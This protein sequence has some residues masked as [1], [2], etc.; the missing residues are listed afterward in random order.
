MGGEGQPQREEESETVP[1]SAAR[2]SYVP[3]ARPP[4]LPRSHSSSAGAGTGTYLPSRPPPAPPLRPRTPPAQHHSQ[5][6]FSSPTRSIPPSPS[7]HYPEPTSPPR[8]P[9]P[10]PL[11]TSLRDLTDALP[12]HS[13]QHSQPSDLPQ[14]TTHATPT[15]HQRQQSYSHSLLS[16][17]ATQAAALASLHESPLSPPR[18]RSSGYGPR[19]WAQSSA[20]GS[21]GS[22]Q[23]YDPA[24]PNPSN[25][26]D[27]SDKGS[28]IKGV[29]GSILG[30]SF[31][32]HTLQRLLTR[33][34]RRLLESQQETRNIN[35]L[36]PRPSHPRRLQ[37]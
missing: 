32:Q 20:S 29:F 37:L 33:C 28:T 4:F 8:R 24:S 36:R 35:S 26:K 14:A 31:P 21:T 5:P 18:V 17:P 16:D 34:C 23:P 19:D 7:R 13:T 1:P 27:R 10:P 22:A 12:S 11:T 6:P 30:H 3:T 25:G 9:A 2:S 15:H